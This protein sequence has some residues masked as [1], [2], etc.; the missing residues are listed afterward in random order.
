MGMQAYFTAPVPRWLALT[1][2]VGTGV[3]AGVGTYIIMDRRFNA[4][5]EEKVNEEVE[6]TTRFLAAI[7]KVEYPTP[8][9]AVAALYPETEQ[10]ADLIEELQYASED[11]SLVEVAVVEVE[12]E[13]VIEDADLEFDFEAEAEN[14]A[15]GK[16]YILE[17][18]EFQEM[19]KPCICLQWFDGDGVLVDQDDKPVIDANKIVGLKNLN[20]FGYGSRDPNALYIHNP[21][22]DT[23]YEVVREAGR[24]VDVDHYGTIQHAYDQGGNRKRTLRKFHLNEE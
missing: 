6:K 20:R 2:I 1:A 19:D 22:Y 17:Y 12:V 4:L 21:Y 3:A 14:R 13:N 16:P 5:F 10:V 18:N 11:D 23:N 7:K 24:Y 15:S 8:E 9:D